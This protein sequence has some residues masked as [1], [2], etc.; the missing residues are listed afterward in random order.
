MVFENMML[1]RT[2]GPRHDE[3][4]EGQRKVH[5]RIR[6]NGMGKICG[7]VDDNRNAYR[8]LVETYEGKRPPRRPRHWWIDNIKMVLGEIG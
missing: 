5:H 4:T 1:R 7:T 8:L 3:V 6:D 2:Y